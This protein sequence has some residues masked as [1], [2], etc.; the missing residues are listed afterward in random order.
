[1]VSSVEG[2]QSFA[3][4]QNGLTEGRL[5]NGVG[6]APTR[7]EVFLKDRS[8]H[9]NERICWTVHPGGPI[10]CPPSNSEPGESTRMQNNV[11]RLLLPLRRLHRY[12][13]LDY[14]GPGLSGH[15]PT[16][17]FFDIEQLFHEVLNVLGGSDVVLHFH[18]FSPFL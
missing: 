16:F 1:M 9:G 4:L 11:L 10:S 6:C 14:S 3:R 12:G 15:L 7:P 17:E 13:R 2:F 18:C 5:P 8:Y